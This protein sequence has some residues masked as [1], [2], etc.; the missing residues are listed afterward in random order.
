MHAPRRRAAA[1]HRRA[2]AAGLVAA[3]SLA[4]G[5]LGRP[6]QAQAV[7]APV[8]GLTHDLGNTGG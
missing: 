4:L 6:A 7:T 5:L 2:A 8:F 3:G 1:G